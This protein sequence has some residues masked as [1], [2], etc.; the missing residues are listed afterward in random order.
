MPTL[1]LASASPRR[2]ELLRRAG[3]DPRVLA[4]KVPEARRRGESPAAMVL[5]LARAKAGEVAGL[6]RAKG[7]REGLVLAADTTVALGTKVLEKPRHAAQAVTMLKS[8]SGRSHTV[9]TGVCVL[10]LGPVPKE[11]A[12]FVEATK[13]FFRGLSEAEIRDY[14]ATG[15]PLD[16]AGAYGIQGAAAAFVRRIEGD[17]CNV[18]GLPLARVVEALSS[19]F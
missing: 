17:Y 18:V 14:V 11:S 10:S 7:A 16:K 3:F 8:L 6:L 4:S 12:A 1:Y 9:H 2:V 19:Q 15:E 5:R 13:V